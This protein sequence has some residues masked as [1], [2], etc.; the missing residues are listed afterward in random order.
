MKVKLMVLGLCLG[1]TSYSVY[2]QEFQTAEQVRQ[3]EL[4][5]AYKKKAANDAEVARQREAERKAAENKKATENPVYD[6]KGT[7]SSETKVI[8][9]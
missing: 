2:G 6:K 8:Q 5:K 4:A 1:F 7:K 3:E 9:R